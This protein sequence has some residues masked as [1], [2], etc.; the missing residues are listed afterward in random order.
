M[1]PSSLF[2]QEILNPAVEFP[3]EKLRHAASHPQGKTCCFFPPC[4]CWSGHVLLTSGT[5]R[6]S[7]LSELCSRR[8]QSEASGSR[9]LDS[10]KRRANL[11]SGWLGGNRPQQSHSSCQPC[12]ML[13][14]QPDT[15]THTGNI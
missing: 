12:S 1:G 4:P 13:N 9:S 11:R 8:R 10:R 2:V 15:H 6:N 7:D 14:L 3:F 5:E